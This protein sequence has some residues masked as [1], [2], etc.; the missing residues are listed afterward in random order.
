MTRRQALTKFTYT[1]LFPICIAAVA[2]IQRVSRGFQFAKQATLI[3]LLPSMADQMTPTY[4]TNQ[5]AWKRTLDVS[6]ELASAAEDQSENRKRAYEV[7]AT[8][9]ASGADLCLIVLS[10]AVSSGSVQL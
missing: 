4:R 9:P 2:I 5:L 3:T 10:I 1:V 7:T 6:Y 8:V